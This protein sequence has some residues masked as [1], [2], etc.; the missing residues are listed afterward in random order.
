MTHRLPRPLHPGAWWLWALGMATAASRTTNPIT[1][2]VFAAV[3]G[4]VVSFRRTDAPW[5]RGFS[6]YLKLGLLILAF[7]VVFRVLLD[8]Q[9]GT[10]VLFTLPELRLP[11]AAAGIRIG[12]PVSL[13]GMLA[14][15]Y[16]G[17]RLATLLLCLGAANVLADPKRLL[18]SLP[19]A[20]HEMGVAVTVA[21][22]VAPQLI[23]S[24]QR[25]RRA[26]KLRGS[27]GGRKGVVRGVLIP[28]LEDALDRSLVLAA[29]MDSRGYGRRSE[30]SRGTR[31]VTAALV[32]GGVVGV[33]VGTYGVLDG[34][35]P[36]ALG[37]PVL[38]AGC[39][40]AVVGIRVGG[41]R[42]RR[43]VYRPDRWGAAEWMVVA[44]GIAAAAAMFV[45]S[46]V[47]PDNLYPTL[48]PLRW[49]MLGVLPAIAALIGVLPAVLAPPV[50]VREAASI[51]R[52][53]AVAP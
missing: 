10:T 40:V 39:L 29:A 16:D 32:L 4:C 20:L 12:G 21:L 51:A 15:L 33:C 52:D 2:V 31:W 35:T 37:A 38:A 18:K 27:V 8:G 46:S 7:R 53:V 17:V 13:Q 49:P 36:R 41:R 19:A 34:T 24:G 1:L 48:Q 28:V 25:I 44:C 9:Y 42:V 47:D 3:V 30:Q 5:A 26:R 50:F 6:T 43:S 22:T 45:A 11:H 23:E 14:A